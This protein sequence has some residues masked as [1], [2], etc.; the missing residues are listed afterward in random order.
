MTV[1][2]G[3]IQIVVAEFFNLSLDE[4]LFHS[5]KRVIA[6]PRPIAMFLARQFT[7]ASLREIARLFSCGSYKIVRSSIARIDEQRRT[8]VALDRI[9]REL[10]E[11]LIRKHEGCRIVSQHR[12]RRKADHQD[13]GVVHASG[14][15]KPRDT[16]TGS[17]IVSLDRNQ[18][19]G[20]RHGRVLPRMQILG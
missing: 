20:G 1:T 17:T 15:S 2:I 9:L 8:D 18:R 13:D 14:R 12:S 3:Q 16:E 19:E 5:R 7:G 11:T 4:V 10:S 6:L